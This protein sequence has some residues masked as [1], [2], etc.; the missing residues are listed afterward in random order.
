MKKITKRIFIIAVG[1]FT[2][3]PMVTFASNSN[4]LTL[5]SS[6]QITLF[7]LKTTT[8]CITTNSEKS[9][10]FTLNIYD[11]NGATIYSI[12]VEDEEYHQSAIE[13]INKL[14]GDTNISPQ[15]R[16]PLL[17]GESQ[18]KNETQ[19]DGNAVTYSWKRN[20]AGKWDNNFEGGMSSSWTGKGNC[21]YIVLNQ[22]ISVR[23]IAVSVS[24]PPGVTSSKTNAYWQSKPIYSNIAGA[25]FRN[26]QVGGTA[27]SCTFSENGDVYKGNRIY[28]PIT[29]I[30]F[31]CFS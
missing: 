1:I 18:Y 26:M 12:D 20:T 21:D 8:R 7:P 2:L 31:S 25:S 5:I 23:G 16:G 4:E 29:N 3:I 27:F 19:Y 28:R 24:W 6:E 14:T 13:Y 11:D 9:K 17:P 15:T 10:N 22:G 30:K